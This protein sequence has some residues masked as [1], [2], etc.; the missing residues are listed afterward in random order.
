MIDLSTMVEN[1]LAKH[2]RSKW[3]Q[4]KLGYKIGFSRVLGQSLLCALPSCVRGTSSVYSVQTDL[5]IDE[6]QKAWLS[7]FLC[8]LSVRP[9]Y[10][11]IQS[12]NRPYNIHHFDMNNNFHGNNVITFVK[13]LYALLENAKPVSYS[14]SSHVPDCTG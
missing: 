6:E 1:Q 4:G 8:S 7:H 2:F 11:W 5:M 9:H 10:V 13:H 3:S 12:T 14:I